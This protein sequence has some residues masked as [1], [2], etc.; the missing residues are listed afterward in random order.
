M[1][2]VYISAMAGLEQ[3][4]CS[5]PAR[6]LPAPASHKRDQ[7][8]SFPTL[9]HQLVSSSSAH[10]ACRIL[11][12]SEILSLCHHRFIQPICVTAFVTDKKQACRQTL[13][14]HMLHFLKW[15]QCWFISKNSCF[16]ELQILLS[17]G[18]DTLSHWSKMGHSFTFFSQ[19]V[20]PE[21][22]KK[23]R[24]LPGQ[25]LCTRQKVTIAPSSMSV[26]PTVFTC[27]KQAR[28]R[29]EGG[30]TTHHAPTHR[31]ANIPPLTSISRFHNISTY[32][33]SHGSE[34]WASLVFSSAINSGWN[35][36]MLDAYWLTLG[37]DTQRDLRTA[38]EIT[39]RWCSEPQI[40][41]QMLC[42]TG[43]FFQ[44]TADLFILEG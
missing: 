34:S 27:D 41:F 16:L 11:L 32:H 25:G 23:N 5:W 15:N 33:E 24:R 28:G 37:W 21:E 22:Q 17:L 18:A 7:H 31:L 26:C 8:K 19:F 35:V 14:S 13:S 40:E 2:W 12:I 4:G 39:A 20:L 38:Q 42:F 43:N 1:F 3:A 10:R 29:K 6:V 30:C 44:L 36:L 9:G